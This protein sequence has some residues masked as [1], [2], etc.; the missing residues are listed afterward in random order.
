MLELLTWLDQRGCSITT[1][2]QADIDRWVTHNPRPIHSG[3]RRFLA[4][5]RDRHGAP[6]LTVPQH[7]DTH[8]SPRPM[9]EQAATAQLRRCLH[10]ERLPVD[11]RVAGATIMLFGVRMARLVQL[12]IDDVTSRDGAV[13]L[14]AGRAPIR[15]PSPLDRLLTR[16]VAA[17]ADPSP[18]SRAVGPARFLFPGTAAG[19]PMR[20]DSLNRRL[21]RYQI[22]AEP[23]RHNALLHLAADLPAAI[24]ADLLG[25]HVNTILRWAEHS[26]GD[27]TP[28]SWRALGPE[29]QSLSAIVSG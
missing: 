28:I 1:I 23:A 6:P 15:M 7:P 4:W 29:R 12:T 10:D 24:L 3:I 22:L 11:V 13:W 19:R 9:D 21:R 20:P 25:V 8:L 14:V 17:P 27:W 18:I 2:G 16:L 26:G 5:A